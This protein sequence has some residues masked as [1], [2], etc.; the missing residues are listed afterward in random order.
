VTDSPIPISSRGN[1]AASSRSVIN[2]DPKH[3]HCNSGFFE[4]V[5]KKAM[6]LHGRYYNI[7]RG[8]KGEKVCFPETNQ[9]SKGAFLLLMETACT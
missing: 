4:I 6:D 3:R 7:F 9:F 1:F 2:L 8:K 5:K